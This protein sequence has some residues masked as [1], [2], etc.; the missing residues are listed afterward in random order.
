MTVIAE[1]C[2]VNLRVG[3]QNPHRSASTRELTANLCLSLSLFHIDKGLLKRSQ[4]P[5]KDLKLQY[6]H[7]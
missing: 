7:Q 1:L 5:F 3:N 2:Q 4:T 6:Y